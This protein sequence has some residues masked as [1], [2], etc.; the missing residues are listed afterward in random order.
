M[1]RSILTHSFRQ[2]LTVSP[3]KDLVS[4]QNLKIFFNRIEMNEI[5][6]QIDETEK[7]IE[8][9]AGE[10]SAGCEHIFCYSGVPE[11]FKPKDRYDVIRWNFFNQ[12]HIVYPNDFEAVQKLDGKLQFEE[13]D[14]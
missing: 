3:V 11:P 5:Q 13:R 10:N 7:Y 6:A 2:S 9:I 14:F 1:P 8:Q 4:I 12:T